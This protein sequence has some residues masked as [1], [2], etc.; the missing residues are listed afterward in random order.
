M[1]EQQTML[2]VF[3]LKS[4]IEDQIT[5]AQRTGISVA[6]AANVS[7]EEFI[8][9]A[10]FQRANVRQHLNHVMCIIVCLLWLLASAN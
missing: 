10:V 3:F 4:I 5:E 9:T 8:Q 1:E 6:S 7:D 2:A